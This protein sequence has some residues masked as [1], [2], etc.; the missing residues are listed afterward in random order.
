[1]ESCQPFAFWQVQLLRHFALGLCAVSA[2]PDLRQSVKKA[3]SAKLRV[4]GAE[5]GFDL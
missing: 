4:K 5:T 2:P 3:A 1:M